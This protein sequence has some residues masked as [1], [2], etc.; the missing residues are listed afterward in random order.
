MTKKI[1]IRDAKRQGC[2]DALQGLPMQ[3][4][5]R[6]PLFNHY[7]RGYKFG[8][9]K[10]NMAK[11]KNKNAGILISKASFWMGMHWSRYNKRICINLIPFFTVWFCYSGGVTP[12]H[13]FN[14][15]RTD[16]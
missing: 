12:K 14:I 9:K 4:H 6:N 2:Q 10:N 5:K 3:W 16:K 15:W 8:I 1:S 11:S 7:K 13:G